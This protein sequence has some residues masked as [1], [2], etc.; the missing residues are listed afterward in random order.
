MKLA[1]CQTNIIFEDKEKNITKALGFIESAAK[2][3]AD[4]I[5]FPEMS[6]TGF[7]MNI[8]HT[9]ESDNYTINAMLSAAKSHKI[10]IGFGYVQLNS[11]KGKNHYTVI[12][13]SGKILSDYTKIHSFAI[14][15]EREDFISGN[16]LP[17]PFTI[18]SRQI[19][20][21]ICYDLR[22]PEIFRAVADNSTVITIAA[23]WPASR[24]EH[25]MALL[26]A[27]AIENQVYI[28]GIN[29]TGNQDGLQYC[30]DSM[31]IDPWGNV[32]AAAKS[33]DEEMIIC[34]IADDVAQIRKSFPVH[35]SRKF[36]L[37]KSIYNQNR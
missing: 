1:F 14:G 31:V 37:Y 32:I 16:T 17:S 3:G 6:F 34:D 35:E 29:C 28:A 13:S 11:D 25:W 26:K 19:S 4:I 27:R 10:A 18:S 36:E 5:L 9:G 8:S 12:G 7:S 21:F 23:N 2:Q 30:G 33:A 22:F 15:G 20:T 24:R